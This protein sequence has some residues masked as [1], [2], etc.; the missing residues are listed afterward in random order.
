MLNVG[1]CF[2]LL[3]LLLCVV[4][5]CECNDAGDPVDAASLHYAAPGNL[6]RSAPRKVRE[7]VLSSP[8]V[9]RC[10]AACAALIAHGGGACCD[11]RTRA[12]TRSDAEDAADSSQ[13]PISPGGEGEMERDGGKGEVGPKKHALRARPGRSKIRDAHSP[14]VPSRSWTV[15]GFKLVKENLRLTFNEPT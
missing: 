10:C 2:F 12:A 13:F 3:M 4:L 14:G 8:C 5:C 6:M 7:T 15:E 11:A 9:C 1:C